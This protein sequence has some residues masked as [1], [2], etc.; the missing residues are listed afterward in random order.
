LPCFRWIHILVDFFGDSAFNGG[1][2]KS[3]PKK[4]K[5]AFGSERSWTATQNSFVQERLAGMPLIQVFNRQEAEFSKFDQINIELKKALLRTV[6]IFSL[7]FPVVELIS[8]LFIG[9]ILFY[10]GFIKSTPGII[11]ALYSLLIC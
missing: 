4:L 7:F 1:Y 10:G 2:H 5:V 11:I 8:S 9:F 3:F 6:F